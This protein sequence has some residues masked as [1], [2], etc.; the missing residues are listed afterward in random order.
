M[1]GDGLGKEHLVRGGSLPGCQVGVEGE[2]MA[3]LPIP[4]NGLCS[5]SVLIASRTPGRLGFWRENQMFV[6]R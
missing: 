5:F 2:G 6:L 1:R 3:E 4:S